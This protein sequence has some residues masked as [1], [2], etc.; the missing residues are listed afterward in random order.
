MNVEEA[1]NLIKESMKDIKQEMVI[2]LD[3]E[4]HLVYIHE[5][6]IDKTGKIEF[7][8]STP[9]EDKKEELLPHIEKCIQLQYEDYVVQERDKKWKSLKSFFR[10]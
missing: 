3:G 6:N 4:N 7:K 8:F 9:S 5:I 2:I 10:I 1:H